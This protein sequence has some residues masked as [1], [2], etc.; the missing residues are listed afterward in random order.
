MALQILEFFLALT[1]STSEEIESS[2]AI[3]FSAFSGTSL[4]D[5]PL[6]LINLSSKNYAFRAS[7]IELLL[8]SR[9]LQASLSSIRPRNTNLFALGPSFVLL[10][11]DIWT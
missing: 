3:V 11:S 1:P 6:S 4:S 10:I 9:N 7:M 2:G 8:R 5:K